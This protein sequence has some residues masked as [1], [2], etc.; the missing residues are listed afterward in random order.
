MEARAT[1][2]EEIS[3]VAR[4]LRVFLDRKEIESVKDLEK[5]M[6]QAFSVPGGG[7]GDLITMEIR[8]S[9]FGSTAYTISYITPKK[10]IPIEVSVNP[11]MNYSRVILKAELRLKDYTT[12]AYDRFGNHIQDRII[13][14]CS[15]S[16]VKKE[17]E[18]LS[19]AN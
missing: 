18:S 14:G 10:G 2:R 7:P 3:D 5:K 16:G 8:P 15:I 11:G 4:R 6:G 13:P 19:G 12:F 9:D 1:T 17:L